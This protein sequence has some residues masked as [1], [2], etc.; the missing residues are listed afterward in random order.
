MNVIHA[1]RKDKQS[2]M[3]FQAITI[4]YIACFGKDQTR[5]AS[6]EKVAKGGA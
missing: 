5:A 6:R 1:I 3:I 2:V 4:C